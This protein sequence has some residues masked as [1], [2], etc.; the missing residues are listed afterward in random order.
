MFVTLLNYEAIQGHLLC[1]W[2]HPKAL[3]KVMCTKFLNKKSTSYSMFR[4]SLCQAKN[5]P[6]NQKMI[7]CPTTTTP[8]TPLIG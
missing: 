6:S 7:I 4:T 1:V 3:D 8:W 5:F 2:Y